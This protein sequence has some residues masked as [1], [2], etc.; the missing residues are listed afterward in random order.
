MEAKATVK[1]LRVPARKARRV[2]DVIRGQ[3]VDRALTLLDFAPVSAAKAIRKI[4]RSAI[5]NAENNHDMKPGDLV[6][7]KASVDGG[8]SFKRLEARARG[9]AAFKRKRMSHVTIVV[10]DG[11]TE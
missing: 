9:Q 1:F 5:A 8:P 3:R 10:S 6:I 7:T 4:L 11:D 2:V